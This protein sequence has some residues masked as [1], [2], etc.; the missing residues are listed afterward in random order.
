M[1]STGSRRTR[2]SSSRRARRSSWSRSRRTRTSIISRRTRM[3]SSRRTRRRARK[4][5][6][7]SSWSRS[8]RT[9]RTDVLPLCYT[10]HSTKKSGARPALIFCLNLCRT[11]FIPEPGAGAGRLTH[12]IGP[13]TSKAGAAQKSDCSVTLVQILP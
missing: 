13:Q 6:R 8:G 9:R 1:R 3:S 11:F 5:T 12:N 10:R 2:K 7:R 4:W